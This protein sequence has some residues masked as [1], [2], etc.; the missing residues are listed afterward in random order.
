MILSRPLRALLP[1]LPT[2]LISRA[3]AS[4]PY[5]LETLPK[6]TQL[7]C[8][9]RGMPVHVEIG[10]EIEEQVLRLGEYDSAS[11]DVIRHF[12]KPGMVCID[13]GANVGLLSMLMAHLGASVYAF[14]PGPPYV[15]RMKAN[16]RLNSGLEVR[17]VQQGLSDTPG[18]LFWRADPTHTYNAGLNTSVGV[19]VPVTTLDAYTADLGR[20]DFIKIDVESMELEVLKGAHAMLRRLKP[21]LYFETME[22]ARK[23]RGFDVFAEIEGLLKDAGYGM[24]DLLDGDLVEVHADSLPLNTIGRP[25]LQP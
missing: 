4:R 19:R 12:V 20:V 17:I 24:Y 15:A 23:A 16:L 8:R 5:L 14:E 6:G 11:C 18:T 22:W 2:A 13:V 1:H 21:T 7:V 25:L 9:Y 10:N 3:I